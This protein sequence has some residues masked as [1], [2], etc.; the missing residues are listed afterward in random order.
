MQIRLNGKLHEVS[1]GMTVAR[2]LEELRIRHE[3]V[4]VLVNQ[5][6]VKRPLYAST[7]LQDGD[8]V[9]VLTVMAGGM[10]VIR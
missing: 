4:A 6:V 10:E 9:E 8:A 3:R 5:G 7:T 2:L 1:H